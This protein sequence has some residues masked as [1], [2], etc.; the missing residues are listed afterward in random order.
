M[1]R[2]IA[3]PTEIAALPRR[4]GVDAPADHAY[5]TIVLLR[6]KAR[7]RKRAVTMQDDEVV[8][9]DGVRTTLEDVDLA[10][11][12][13]WIFRKR[14]VS[15]HQMK[16]FLFTG[17]PLNEKGPKTIRRECCLVVSVDDVLTDFVK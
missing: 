10:L 11:S 6:L 3:R 14:G 1:D 7:L 2:L 15:V 5:T 12:Q 17:F 9:D 4:C 13:N 8:V 16:E